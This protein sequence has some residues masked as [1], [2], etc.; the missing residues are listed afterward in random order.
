MPLRTE[1]LTHLGKN[2]VKNLIDKPNMRGVYLLVRAVCFLIFI[3][4]YWISINLF[5]Y[6][7]YA[8]EL[9]VPSARYLM[10]RHLESGFWTL[11]I[12]LL[13]LN[14]IKVN[15]IGDSLENENALI[16]SNHR[17]IIDHVIFP[18][19][20]RTVL[21]E[22][23]I[24]VPTPKG[25]LNTSE[26]K[27]GARKDSFK[28]EI[29]KGSKIRFKLLS[30]EEKILA[31]NLSTM[32]IPKINFFTWYEIWCVPTPNYFKHISQADENWE[33]DGETLVS[34]F[35]DYLDSPGTN[36][37]Q[38]L[39]LF[40]EVN[41]FTEKDSRMQNISGERHYLPQ[42]QKVLYPRFGGF[43]NAIGGLYKTKY[44]RLYDITTIYY[45]RNKITGAIVDFKPPSLLGILGV[46][47]NY[48]ETVIFVHV[49]GKFLNRV[50]LKRN[51]LEKYLENRWI[52]K[53]KLIEKLERRIL[54]ENVKMMR[55]ITQVN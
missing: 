7:S 17:S 40:P 3:S 8:F 16:I 50:P 23:L 25:N 32:L 10:K 39:T 45:T 4:L 1:I 42:F 47:D 2:E 46:K 6:V 37:T 24:E 36:S 44:T 21:D 26:K 30:N 11:C 28:K 41:I 54:H 15:I 14:E 43:A 55:D 13:E 38:W 29:K 48:I 20:S 31:K 22:E 19:L 52:K 12:Y 34:I 5:N 49:A 35:Q 33:L 18:F 51:K 27:K 53:D 9:T